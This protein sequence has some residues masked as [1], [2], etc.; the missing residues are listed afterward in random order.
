MRTLHAQRGQT[1][2]VWIFGILTLLWLMMAVFNYANAVRWQI[3]A[4]NAADSVAQG[5][6]SVQA[7]HFN[8]IT[9]NVHAAG[10]EEY[11]IRRTM[12]AMLNLLKGSGGCKYG[13]LTAT[14][15][16]DC[17]AAYNSLR[18]NYIQQV[19]RY[20]QLVQ[21][22]A[23]LS[24]YSQTQ[25]LADMQTIADQ[26]AS[27]CAGGN[28]PTAGDCA[29]KYTIAA[30][31]ARPSLSGALSDAGGEDNGDGVPLPNG[32]AIVSDLNPLQIEVDTCAQV[33]SPF[34]ALWKLGGTQVFGLAA[35]F[36]AVGRAGATTTLVTQEW[37]NPGL[38]NNPQSPSQ[39]AYNGPEFVESAT[40]SQPSFYNA[41]TFCNSDNAAYDWY[42]V[43]WCANNW[44]S[45]TNN[46]GNNLPP[47]F[48]GYIAGI[49]TEEFST[50][51]GWWSAIPVSPYSGTF[52]PAAGNCNSNT[53]W[54]S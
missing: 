52:T 14:G 2:P 12:Q 6:V 39:G 31:T 45:I 28:S 43:H 40:D 16:I 11:R 30:P 18:N 9:A 53:P 10:I 44:R 27:H 23:A 26:Y 38:Q 25:Q 13:T 32:G 17:A 3:R 37:F 50:W 35:P 49:T 47:V 8:S 19:A 51:T 46:P 4:Q 42:A 20:G 15:W 48:G 5:I 1:F 21:Q 34:A 41:G 33:S 7:A 24:E 54:N 22:M 29:F 36:T